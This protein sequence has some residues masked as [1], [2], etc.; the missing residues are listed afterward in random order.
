M[1]LLRALLD[2]RP[3]GSRKVETP[4]KRWKFSKMR[5]R[6]LAHF[7]EERVKADGDNEGNKMGAEGCELSISS[8]AIF[9][10][11]IVLH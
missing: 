8:L 1:Q 6:K 5:M 2:S 9:L 10:C 7:L 4:R 3:R 11:R